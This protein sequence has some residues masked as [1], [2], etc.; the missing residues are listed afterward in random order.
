MAAPRAHGHFCKAHYAIA[1]RPY[2]LMPPLPVACPWPSVAQSPFRRSTCSTAVSAWY[3]ERSA[4]QATHQSSARASAV[5]EESWRQSIIGKVP[6]S[7]EQQSPHYIPAYHSAARG[8]SYL[9]SG[10]AYQGAISARHLGDGHL[11]CSTG[12]E[13]RCHDASE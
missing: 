13:S 4:Q 5:A 7:P 8:I 10:S 9:I 11:F 6:V 1:L 2:S 12:G 3:A